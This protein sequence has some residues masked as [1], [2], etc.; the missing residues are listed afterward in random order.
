MK[1]FRDITQQSQKLYEDLI[2]QQETAI[3]ALKQ[4]LSTLSV[5]D[6]Y[7]NLVLLNEQTEQR[8]QSTITLRTGY[9]LISASLITVVLSYFLHR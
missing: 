5:N 2:S 4:D 8:L 1:E 3:N 9:M 7:G 6:S